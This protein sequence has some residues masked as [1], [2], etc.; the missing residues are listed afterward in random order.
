LKFTLVEESRGEEGFAVYATAEVALFLEGLDEEAW[1][2]V[3]ALLESVAEHGIPRN[4]EKSKKLVDEIYELKAYQVRLAYLYG[5]RRRT[6]LMIHG[7]LK[8]S[9]EWPKN[10]LKVA[11]RVCAEAQDALRK[12]TIEHVD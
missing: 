1:E 5:G 10:H 12:G 4:R 6:I 8:K 2:K 7:F 3:I 9:D 11:K